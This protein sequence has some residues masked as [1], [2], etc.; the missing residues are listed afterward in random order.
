[1]KFQKGNK[2]GRGRKPICLN[3]PELLLPIIL[4]KARIYWPLEFARLYRISKTKYQTER[5]KER[6]Q[7]WV[8]MMPYLCTRI[9]IKDLDA[10]KFATDDDKKA[11]SQQT[12]D[13]IKALEVHHA[14]PKSTGTN[15]TTG[16]AEGTPPVPPSA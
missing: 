16:V 1:M 8:T 10:S 13:L 9:A 5:H 14:N 7:F 11:M 4:Q 15:Q 2:F 12:E 6:L 3:K